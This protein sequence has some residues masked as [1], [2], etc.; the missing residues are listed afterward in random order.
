LDV[1]ILG[2]GIVAGSF[3]RGTSNCYQLMKKK[4]LSYTLVLSALCIPMLAPAETVA[5]WRFEGDGLSTPTLGSVIAHTSSRTT[6]TLQGGVRVIDVSGNGNTLYGWNGTGGALRY[7]NAVPSGWTGTVSNMFSVVNSGTTPRAFTWSTQSSPGGIN[8]DTIQPLQWTIEASVYLSSAGESGWRTF[9][10]RDGAGVAPGNT[11]LA[12]LYFQKTSGGALRLQ[13]VDAAGNAWEASDT[14]PFLTERWYHVAAVSDGTQLRLYKWDTMVDGGYQL[15]A[16]TD[17]SSSLDPRLAADTMSGSALPLDS[18]GD[19]MNWSIGSGMYASGDQPESG[20]VDRWLGMID[21]VRIS[22]HVLNP[23]EFLFATPLTITDVGITA[24]GSPERVWLE[25][26]SV[27][28][29]QYRVTAKTNLTQP[30]WTP[31]AIGIMATPPLNVWTS[32]VQNAQ[33][34][35]FRVETEIPPMT[36]ALDPNQVLNS[37]DENIYGHFLEHIYHSANGGLW[38]ELVWNRSFET[39]PLEATAWTIVG[40][41][42]VQNTTETNVRLLFGNVAW[43]DYEF[44]LQARKDGGAEGFL[45]LFRT[46]GGD[47]YWV[48][49]GGWGNTRHQLEKGNDGGGWGPVGPQVAGSINNDQW[50]DI[51]IRCEGNWFRVWLDNNLIIDWTD[52]SGA[53]LTGQVGVGTW[54]TQARFRNLLVQDLGNNTLYSGLPDLSGEYP[55]IDWVPY[56]PTSVARTTDAANSHAAAMLTKTNATEGGLHQTPFRFDVQ[57]YTGSLWAKGSGVSGITVRLKDGATILAQTNLPPPT[58]IWQKHAFSLTPSVQASNGTLE[59]AFAGTGTAYLDQVSLM[60]QDSLNT[61]GYRP[62]LLAAAAGLQPPVIRWPGGCFASA[63]RWKY[64]IGPQDDRI[65]HPIVQWDDQDV[66]SFGTDEFIRMC[67]QIGT[68]PILVINVGI[69]GVC[70][71]GSIEDPYPSDA[72]LLQDA[73]DWIEYCNGPTNT[74]WGALRAANGHPEPYNV[75]YWEI[76]N[77][78]WSRGSSWYAARVNEYAP[79]MRAADPTIK[80]IAVGSGWADQSWN[81]AILDQCATNIDYISVHSYLDPSEYATGPLAYEAYI[82]NL[83]G[84]IASSSNPNV[85]IYNSEWNAQSIDLRTGL[86]AGGMLNGFERQGAV[87]TMGGPALMYRHL[88]AAAWNNAFVN[89]DHTGSFVAPNYVV[90]KLWRDHYAPWRIGVSGD[91]GSLNLV[92]TKSDDGGTVIVKVVNPAAIPTR[93]YFTLPGGTTI[94]NA[95]VQHVTAASLT[96]ENSLADPNAVQAT[97]GSAMVAGTAVDVTLPAYS[98]SVLSISVQ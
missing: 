10:G 13:F 63:Y 59:V 38:G 93:V 75:K 50:Y 51:R 66:N 98:A 58:G 88:G 40:N 28:G 23:N 76:D 67:H 27:T 84:R 11:D 78:T 85:K 26:N 69:G 87:F 16:A 94:N 62:D 49:L 86:F 6:S 80:L 52:T 1:L 97:A 64:G 30:T 12:C 41:D 7:T 77:E 36:L 8:V 55:P 95:T 90:M 65:V 96:T 15:V 46:D 74:T 39:W 57:A 5:Y 25:W 42:L 47:F 44:I 14:E 81:Q 79:L 17:I 60:G 68:E 34:S 43:T 31:Q 37:I 29:A 22:N 4:S 53:H 48:N 35:F 83:A 24:G 54:A 70:G 72:E 71:A 45:I 56:G 19:P 20:H 3:G 82:V 61:G 91:A 18:A 9:I 73:L 32:G 89:F 21:E 92:A 2:A 33:H